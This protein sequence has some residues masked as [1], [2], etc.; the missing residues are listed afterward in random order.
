M[1]GFVVVQSLYPSPRLFFFSHL[2]YLV[3]LSSVRYIGWCLCF[4]FLFIMG[5]LGFGWERF[6]HFSGFL[7]SSNFSWDLFHFTRGE[8]Y[9][10][11]NFLL[12]STG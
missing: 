8:G 12:L 10:L 7:P 1:V 6:G 11:K 2:D 4:F 5:A 3:F 9:L